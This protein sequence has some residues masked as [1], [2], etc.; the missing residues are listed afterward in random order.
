MHFLPKQH[1]GFSKN[2]VGPLR[3]VNQTGC[4]VTVMPN[5]FGMQIDLPRS[6]KSS[7]CIELE[8]LQHVLHQTNF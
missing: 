1:V 3:K 6:D 8:I 7:F 4:L 2:H 5:I